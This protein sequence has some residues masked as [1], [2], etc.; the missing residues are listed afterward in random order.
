MVTAICMAMFLFYY[1]LHAGDIKFCLLMNLE[2]PVLWYSVHIA[3]PIGPFSCFDLIYILLTSCKATHRPHR[4]WLN[5]AQLYAPGLTLVQKEHHHD[6]I[7]Q[8][9]SSEEISKKGCTNSQGL[10]GWIAFFVR[11]MTDV[12]LVPCWQTQLSK[13]GGIS[14]WAFTVTV[15]KEGQ[16][17]GSKPFESAHKH[18]LALP[19]ASSHSR[20]R[21]HANKMS[22]FLFISVCH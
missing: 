6:C 18:I 13:K 3:S 19:F 8:I 9:Q 10:P 5:A 17:G 12:L 22:L 1:W 4:L 16:K 11:M 15:F 2:E 7:F 14:M 20:P 21:S